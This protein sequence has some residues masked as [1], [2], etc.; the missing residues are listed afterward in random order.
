M[1]LARFTRP[2]IL[3]PVSFLATK[4][5]KPT[6]DDLAKLMRVVRYLAGTR[7]EGLV[8][9][10]KKKFIPGITAD[11][12]HHLHTSGHGQHG[13]TISN[14]S[15]PVGYRSAKITMMTRSSSESELYSLEDASTYAL[16][17][18]IL[19]KDMGVEHNK[20]IKI[21]QDNKS[22]IIMAMQGASFK[23]TK[24]L[25][26]KQ[27]FVKERIQNGDIV[28]QYLP[29]KDMPADMLTKPLG[30]ETLVR[31]KRLLYLTPLV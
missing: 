23:R 11:A 29:T 16:W 8:Y 24:H 21:Y 22:T 26:G 4:C 9:D 25:I 5:S 13:M 14:G 10:S 20:P 12:S 1:Y 19:L 28:L 6:E 27:T 17:Y 31:L 18:Q 3:M 15:A 2:D 30:R 7:T